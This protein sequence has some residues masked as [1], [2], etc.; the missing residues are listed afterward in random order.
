MEESNNDTLFSASE[1]LRYTRHVQLPQVGAEG[2]I[3][4]KN[5]RVLIVGVGG[6][7]CPVSLYLAA[8]GVGS[9]T[10]VDGDTV[11]VSNLQ[12]QILFNTKQVG[13]GKAESAKQVLMALNPEINVRAIAEYLSDENAPI[14]VASADLIIDCTDNFSARYLINDV[15]QQQQKPWIFAAIHQFSGQCSLFSSETGCFRCLFP[16][17]PF[18]DGT[19][20][21][22][23]S[24]GVLGVLPGIL[25]TIQANE[26]LKYLVGQPVPLRGTLLLV[27]ALELSFKNI[28]INRD[29]ECISCGSGRENTRDQV[30]EKI[31]SREQLDHRAV[32]VEQFESLRK[33]ANYI[34]VDVR[35]HAEHAAFNLGGKHMPLIDLA[36]YLASINPEKTLLCYCQSGL[37][38]LQASELIES[39]GIKSQSLDGGITAWL[40]QM[41]L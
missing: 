24:A 38:S 20:E 11:D 12:R 27:D 6:L 4:L 31:C 30:P 36:E 18:A 34:L 2:Q 17:V 39:F 29:P 32:T 7:G 3:K 22:C 26:A 41:S 15:C 1:W 13:E 28:A 5:A 25:G 14:L 19:M 35:S 8:A 21:D 9:I 40:K 33:N 16:V 10:V 37:R 23:N